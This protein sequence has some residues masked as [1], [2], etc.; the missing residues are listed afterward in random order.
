MTYDAAIVK[1]TSLF[2]HEMND[3]AMRSFLMDMK[4]DATTP[5]EVI[6][7]AAHVMRSFAIPLPIS[8]ELRVN[9]LDIVGT[10][11]DKIGSFNIS[12]TVAIL[13]ASLWCYCSKTREPV[14][15][16]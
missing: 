6:A 12:S 10:G 3:D 14:Y 13:T 7:A 2:Q 1:F 11:G 16:F 15:H 5:V 8:E 4:L 9:A